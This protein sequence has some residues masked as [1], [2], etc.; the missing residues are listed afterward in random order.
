MSIEAYKQAREF[1]LARRGDYD[2]AYRDFHWPQMDRFNW[3][4]DWFDTELARGQL[5]HRP[6]LTIVGDGAAS[7]T[8]AELSERSNRVANGLRALGVRRGDRILLMLGNVAP[9]WEGMLAAMKL[10][11]AAIPAPTRP[12][13]VDLPDPFGPARPP[14]R[15]RVTRGA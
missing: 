5:A 12:T 14:R 13:P 3:A 15:T 11:A 1:L 4:L 7:L 8:F 10:G 9:L 6:A 2:A